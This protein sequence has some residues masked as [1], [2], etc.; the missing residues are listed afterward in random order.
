MCIEFSVGANVM[1]VLRQRQG[2]IGRCL[3]RG[4][5]MVSLFLCFRSEAHPP[6]VRFTIGDVVRHTQDHYYGVIVGWDDRCQVQLW[7]T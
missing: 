4:Y 5:S 1:N 2:S 3:A 7:C 6:D